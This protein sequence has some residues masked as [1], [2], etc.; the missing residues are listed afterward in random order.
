MAFEKFDLLNIE[1][2]AVLNIEKLDGGA[3]E[4]V[5]R[6]AVDVVG[7][8]V[9]EVGADG[10]FALA[11]G[12]HAFEAVFETGDQVAFAEFGVD[13]L[14]VVGVEDDVAVVEGDAGM[15]GDD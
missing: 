7:V 12:L 9:G 3:E 2:F 11:A 5:G 13:G 10:E 4:G 1:K 14:G 6:D 8:A 15:E